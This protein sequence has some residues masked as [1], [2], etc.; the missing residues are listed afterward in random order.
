MLSKLL[1]YEW[2]ATSRI[3]LP[4]YGGVLLLA[5]VNRFLFNANDFALPQAIGGTLYSGFIV[6]A[7]VVTF[8]ILIDRF[9]KS[10]LGDEGYLMFT[11]PVTP[12]RHIM[13]KAIIALVMSA[14]TV[15]AV[16]LSMFLMAGDME[17]LQQFW[18]GIQQFFGEVHVGNGVGYLIESVVVVILFAAVS[19][20]F[21]YLCIAIGHLAKSHRVAVAVGAFFVL[22]IILESLVTAIGDLIGENGLNQI[23]HRLINTFGDFGTVHFVL[24]VVILIQLVFGAIYFF[25]TR[26]ILSNK[27]NL[28]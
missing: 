12:G 8:I 20:L 15:I 17:A 11:L 9:Y 10:L 1:K 21:V 22:T 3:C 4:I 26:Y 27:L 25:A 13:A 5:L 24:V 16:F 6:A 18:D 14:L 19:V 28:E 2:K 7:F 23:Y